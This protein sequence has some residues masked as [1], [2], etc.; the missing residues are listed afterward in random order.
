[1]L[2]SKCAPVGL[3][4]FYFYILDGLLEE[5]SEIINISTAVDDTSTWNL[6]PTVNIH[7]FSRY[8]EMSVS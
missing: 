8:W 4:T 5:K 3:T 7:T 2:N 1:M 6:V